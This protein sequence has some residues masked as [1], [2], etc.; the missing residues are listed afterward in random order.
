MG[1]RDA[2]GECD[3]LRQNAPSYEI[4]ADSA[5]RLAVGDGGGH[6]HEHLSA[7]P[8]MAVG[9]LEPGQFAFGP[10]W[11]A[12]FPAGV[13]Q[14]FLAT[15]VGDTD[16]RITD[17]EV[18]AEFRPLVRTQGVTD[19]DGDVGTSGEVGPELRDAGAAGIDL[20]PEPLRTV[21]GSDREEERA[22]AAGR[23]EH[24]C[25]GGHIPCEVTHS[26]DDARRGDLIRAGAAHRIGE[27]L[28]EAADHSRGGFGLC[29]RFHQADDVGGERRCRPVPGQEPGDVGE[30]GDHV[31]PIGGPQRLP[32]PD[33]LRN[34]LPLALL[35]QPR[36]YLGHYEERSARATAG[37]GGEIVIAPP[38]VG[39]CRPGDSG[40][41]G[42]LGAGNQRLGRCCGCVTHGFTVHGPSKWTAR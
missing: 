21:L 4:G 28:A 42:D 1:C 14:Q 22:D 31:V 11:R 12:Q 29:Q 26:A 32:E 18:G 40:E 30:A 13:E 6:D 25:V 37:R 33:V 36:L 23:I 38:P 7:G 41:T 34:L 17:D 15:P 5:P 16:G 2:G 9:M 19:S 3:D 24:G 35:A 27:P 10:G 39:D 20:L 8:R